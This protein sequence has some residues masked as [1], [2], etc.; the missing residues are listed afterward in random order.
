MLIF[1]FIILFWVNNRIVLNALGLRK[2][3]IFLILSGAVA[4]Y[5]PSVCPVLAPVSLRPF[6]VT[7]QSALVGHFTHA[8][9]STTH[10]VTSCWM[11]FT[12]T[13]NISI[14]YANTWRLGVGN[15]RWDCWRGVSEA[16]FSVGVRS[17]LSHGLFNFQE[18][19]HSKNLF[20]T[21]TEK[22]KK[23]TNKKG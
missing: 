6:L 5:S 7:T 16:M 3:I 11:G 18:L 10:Q 23:K 8:W 14:N 9:G 4:L 1:R 20:N 2:H 17:F 15:I 13:V 12:S 21:L 22:T 19:S